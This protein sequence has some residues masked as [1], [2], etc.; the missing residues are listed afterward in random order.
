MGAETALLI[1]GGMMAYG[2]YRANQAEAASERRNA[3]FYE[4]QKKLTLKAAE[5]DK[6]IFDL[7][8][9]QF[10]G[11]QVNAFAK[12]GVEISDSILMRLAGNKQRI[13]AEGEQ[14]LSTGRRQARLAGMRA[15]S[16]KNNAEYVSSFEHNLLTVGGP[17]VTTAGNMAVASGR[18]PGGSPIG[19][20]SPSGNSFTGL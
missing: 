14:I 15:Q 1:G 3:A 17:L 16:A 6:Q 20:R 8:S 5:M 7:E 2:Q 11:A 12:S 18:N 9:D 10:I 4:E 19:G 13:Q